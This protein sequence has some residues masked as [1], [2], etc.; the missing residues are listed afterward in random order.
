MSLGYWFAYAFR[1]EY[2]LVKSRYFSE[3]QLAI[4]SGTGEGRRQ[5]RVRRAEVAE[6]VSAAT[7]SRT[8]GWAAWIARST[9]AAASGVRVGT[10]GRVGKGD[11]RESEAG[12]T[13]WLG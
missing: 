10:A 12:S 6:F 4:R 11:V 1:S 7:I 13:G 9:K 5:V 8:A 3:E 2:A